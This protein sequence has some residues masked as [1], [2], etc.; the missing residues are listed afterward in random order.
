MKATQCRLGVGR[1]RGQHLQ[2]HDAIHPPVQ[3][4]VDLPHSAGAD[5]I[6]HDVVPQDELPPP[7]PVWRFNELK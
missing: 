4:F 3:R 7:V 1:G 2:R 6:E 5:G